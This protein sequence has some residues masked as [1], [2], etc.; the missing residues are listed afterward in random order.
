MA[1]ASHTVYPVEPAAP[2]VPRLE[3]G[4]HLT[5]DEFERRYDDDPTLKKAELIDGV[6]YMPSP[7]RQDLHSKQHFDLIGWLSRYVTATPGVEG[8]DN[9]SLKLNLKNMPQPSWRANSQERRVPRSVAR[10]RSTDR[11]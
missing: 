3:N 5:R 2:V 6:V 11:G 4:D 10:S 1:T 7:V 8:G 9:G